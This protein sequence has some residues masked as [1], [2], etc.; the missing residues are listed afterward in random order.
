MADEKKRLLAQKRTIR[1]K[2]WPAHRKKRLQ[3]GTWR[4][5]RGLHN[6]MRDH[7]ASRGR[8][9]SIGYRSPGLVRGLSRK[10]GLLPLV[11]ANL[12]QLALADPKEHEVVIASSVGN[13]KRLVLIGEAKKRGLII[14]N[15][16]VE[17]REGAITKATSARKQEQS[18][19]LEKKAKRDKALEERLKKEK[20]DEKKAELTDEEKK[21]QEKAEQEKILTKKEQS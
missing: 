18:A 21:D 4:R 1:F 9:I 2:R 11:V 14:T 15:F 10:R 7:K 13:R 8:A 5:P 20:K 17:K 12:T 19:R 6:K 3:D 16:D